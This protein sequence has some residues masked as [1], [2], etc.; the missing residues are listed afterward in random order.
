MLHDVLRCCA[1]GRVATIELILYLIVRK[2]AGARFQVV[3]GVVSQSMFCRQDI[4]RRARISLHFLAQVEKGC[5][6]SIPSPKFRQDR[7]QGGSNGLRTVIESDLQLR[8]RGK[9]GWHSGETV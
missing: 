5:F 4:P 1:N 8:H 3:P 6:D 2:V 7:R 9:Q